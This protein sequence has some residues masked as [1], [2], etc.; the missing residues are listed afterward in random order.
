MISK[1]DARSRAKAFRRQ[2]SDQ[3]ITRASEAIAENLRD[4]VNWEGIDNLNIYQQISNNN[5][6]S[7]EYFI[8]WV[9]E[10][11]PSVDVHLQNQKPIFESDNF[12][13]IIIPCL[14]IDEAGVRVGY[15]GGSYDKYLAEQPSAIIITLCFEGQIMDKIEPELHDIKPSIIVSDERTIYL[16]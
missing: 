9:T 16:D 5:E 12:D 4:V 15:G 10:A 13:V 2:L 6:V 7:T 3:Y 1:I 11:H 8:N 14:A